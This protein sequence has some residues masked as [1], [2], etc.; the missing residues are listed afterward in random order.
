VPWPVLYLLLDEVQIVATA[1]ATQCFFLARATLDLDPGVALRIGASEQ[2]QELLGGFEQSAEQV[3][4]DRVSGAPYSGAMNA[5]V[6]PIIAPQ[7]SRHCPDR[8]R[9]SEG[10][11]VVASGRHVELRQEHRP[12]PDP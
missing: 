5:A 7:P 1:R 11:L 12:C 2:I 4:R 3:S 8:Q 10:R 6:V 9:C